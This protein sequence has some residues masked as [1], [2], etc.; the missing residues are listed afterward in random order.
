MYVRR[1]DARL[2]VQS[3][4]HGPRHLVA[5]GGWV[6][7]GEVWH[8]VFGRLDGWRCTAVDHRGAGASRHDG[9]AISIDAMAD[10]LLAVLDA[11]DIGRAVLAA[12]SS[13]AAVVLEA[14][15]RAPHRVDGLVLSCGSWR[16]PPEAAVDGFVRALEADH[17]GTVARFVDACLPEPDSDDLRYWGRQALGRSSAADAIAL[18]RSR[19]TVDLE[20]RV[21]AVRA[22]AL[23]VHGL[24]DSI[25][26][27]GESRALAALLPDAVLDEAPG[28]GHVP[29]VTAPKRVVDAIAARF[30]G[31]PAA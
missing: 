28:L 6:A 21:H 12:E 23:L 30:G 19:L 15:L 2:H 31:R 16:R 22:P 17:A 20:S 25:V 4:G 27:P 24:A 1:P 14:A 11:L 7:G 26:P 5:I 3:F 9:G 8:D 29:I 10:D 13:G 18:V